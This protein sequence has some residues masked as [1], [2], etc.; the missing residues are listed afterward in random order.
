MALVE[1]IDRLYVGG[2]EEYSSVKGHK[3]WSWLRVCKEAG[4]DCHRE[5]VGYETRGAPPGKDYLAAR[6]GKLMALNCL[7]VDDPA[8]IPDEMIDEGLR[9][10]KERYDA[11]DKVLSACNS[12]HHRGPTMMLMFLRAIG[13]M[14]DS[15]VASE[16]KYRTLYPKYDPKVG[17]RSHARERWKSLPYFFA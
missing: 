17:M 7:D 11:G 9:F 2:N 13:E 14:P 4:P 16:K 6:R 1:V 15:F 12:G 8:Y 3:G 10:L 5:V